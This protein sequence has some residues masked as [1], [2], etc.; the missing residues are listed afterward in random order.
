M[1]RSQ[2]PTRQLVY[3]GIAPCEFFERSTGYGTNVACIWI[4]QVVR[5]IQ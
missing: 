4:R 5:W 3:L 2:G 1:V